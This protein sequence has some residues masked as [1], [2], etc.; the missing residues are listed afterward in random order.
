MA[1][2]REFQV[3]GVATAKLREPKYV[4]TRGTNNKR[5]QG[6]RWS[7]MF[8]GSI[9]VGRLGSRYGFVGNC[10]NNLAES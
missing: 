3:V 6:A 4:R 7:V 2:G 9:E 5:T 10:L 1:T 8:Q